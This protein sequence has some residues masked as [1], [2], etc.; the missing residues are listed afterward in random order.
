M[1]FKGGI[2][3]DYHKATA[4]L[5]ITNVPLMKRYVVPLAQHLGAPGEVIVA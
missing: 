2:H 4:E 5:E 3:P 1:K